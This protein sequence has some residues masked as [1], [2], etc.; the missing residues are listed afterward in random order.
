MAQTQIAASKSTDHVTDLVEHIKECNKRLDRLAL[1][2]KAM[3]TILSE[4]AGL[5]DIELQSMIS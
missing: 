4:K 3:W 2:N 1:V 5:T